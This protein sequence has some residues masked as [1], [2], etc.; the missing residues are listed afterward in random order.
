MNCSPVPESFIF[1]GQLSHKAGA[2]ASPMYFLNVT[3]FSEDQRTY[4]LDCIR[5]KMS[6]LSRGS[7]WPN[8]PCTIVLLEILYKH[9]RHFEI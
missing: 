7:Q 8:F 5:N 1:S 9:L 6:Q 3:W 4:A 2:V